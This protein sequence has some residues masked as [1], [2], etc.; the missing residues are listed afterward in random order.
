[1]IDDRSAESRDGG[2]HDERRV[3]VAHMAGA[4]DRYHIRRR[5]ES[6]C[7]DRIDARLDR[8]AHCVPLLTSA[9]ALRQIGIGIIWMAAQH[10]YGTADSGVGD[11]T[12]HG[13]V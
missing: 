3:A 13:A 2:R 4:K 7:E 10:Q 5:V 9:S 11:G 8:C 6:F 1:R 12:E